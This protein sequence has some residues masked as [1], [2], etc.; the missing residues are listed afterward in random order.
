M[1]VL[2]LGIGGREHALYLEALKSNLF[3]EVFVIPYNSAINNSYD[4]DLNNNKDIIKFVY[5]NKIDFT[6]TGGESTLING[7][8]DD[9]NKEGLLIFGP[10]KKA[11]QI[12]S[13]KN[14][15]KK[16][17]NDAKVKTAS[18]Y[19]FNDYK[20]A[21][22][23]LYSSQYPIVLKED[24]LRQGKGVYIVESFDEAKK[25]LGSLNEI[26]LV[27]EEFLDG[28]E[29]SAFYLIE[30]N[31][32]YATLPI[33]KDYKRIYDDN[34]GENTGGMGAYTTSIY[35]KYQN[36]IIKEIINPVIKQMND[37]NNSYTGILYAGLIKCK[38]DIK[39]IEFNARLGDP[40]T[41]VI[42]NKLNN[43]LIDLMYYAKINTKQ[44][45]TF[46]EYEYLG[47]VIASNGYPLEYDKGFKISGLDQIDNYYYMNVVK[48]DNDL[49]TNGGRVLFVYDYGKNIE[50]ART[51]V[52]QKINKISFEN[53]Y[54]RRDIG[55]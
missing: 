36:K 27:I 2:I 41:E 12:E 23:Y 32:I 54:Y 17:M 7:I 40:E 13:S 18:H 44:D 10:T 34:L 38:D 53:I 4:I 19:Y 9:F 15:A 33:A 43:N 25:V 8:V 24:G 50:E 31:E 35:D 3:N 45:I 47:V 22:D 20:K 21:C 30:N 37:D 6:I 26:D 5:D 52:Y 28:D 48:E 1:K 39:V 51:K 29:F 49:L 55:L 16:I 11:V 14:Y 46:N 42:I